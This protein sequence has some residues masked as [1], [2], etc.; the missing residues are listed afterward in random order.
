MGT[1]K[2]IPVIP[3]IFPQTAKA[4]MVTKGLKFNDFPNSLGSITLPTIICTIP[5]ASSTI[6]K[7]VSSP[8]C[9]R[10]KIAGK[11]VAIKEPMVGI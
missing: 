7:G 5:T 1:L 2:I 9:K 3:H 11:T 10:L 8:N 4:I 6:K